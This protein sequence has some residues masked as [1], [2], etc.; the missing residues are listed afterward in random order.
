MSELFPAD[1]EHTVTTLTQPS[2]GTRL[3]SNTRAHT[4]NRSPYLITLATSLY[5][6]I[7]E[8]VLEF[9]KKSADTTYRQNLVDAK[10]MERVPELKDLTCQDRDF[11][12]RMLRNAFNEDPLIHA[13]HDGTILII[14]WPLPGTKA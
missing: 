8:D 3:I 4:N 10:F 2:L 7:S 13:Y 12:L 5:K 11:I 9:S 1:E 14:S 6:I